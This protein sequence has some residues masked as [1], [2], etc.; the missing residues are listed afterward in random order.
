MTNL[1]PYPHGLFKSFQEIFLIALKSN[2]TM[3]ASPHS[4]WCKA[5][6]AGC[7][8]PVITHAGTST[9]DI[10]A[11]TQAACPSFLCVETRAEGWCSL[12][13]HPIWLW[14]AARPGMCK[15]FPSYRHCLYRP[16]HPCAVIRALLQ[17]RETWPLFAKAALS[18]I[19]AYLLIN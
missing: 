19:T 4:F 17:I 6:C 1:P 16:E 9:D 15:A 3:I 7:R 18:S 10:A 14:D 2:F 5:W 11:H 8:S 13:S 12:R